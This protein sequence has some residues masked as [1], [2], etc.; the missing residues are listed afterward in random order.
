[1]VVPWFRVVLA[2]VWLGG[3]LWL[4]ATRADVMLAGHP[5][6]VVLVTLGGLLGVLLLALSSRRHQ[7]RRGRSW[8]LLLGRGGAAVLTLAVVGALVWLRPFGAS[9]EAVEAMSGTAQVQVT[10]SSTRITLTPTGVAPRSGLVF[11]PGARVDP[12][13]YVPLLTRVAE[14]GSLVVVVKQPLDIGFTA[15]DAPGAVLADHP[16]VR[17]WA[18]GGHSLG[19]VVAASYA[20]D[21]PDQVS[22]LLLWASYPLDPLAD[23]TDLAVTSVSGTRDGLA[24]P[25]DITASLDDLPP[26]TAVVTVE[27]GVHAF[28]GD[29]GVQPGDGTPTVDR[30]TAQEQVVEAS[31]ALLA[32]LP[33]R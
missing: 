25:E 23:R 2:V 9:V 1:M 5:L 33:D 10:S 30:A 16:E 28:F 6:Y 8:R 3:G 32:G 29:Y 31:R 15:V 21:H 12:R 17:R 18:V 27:G 4:W 11:Q 14:A 7:P 13:A 19:G 26:D 24:T 20:G 22:G